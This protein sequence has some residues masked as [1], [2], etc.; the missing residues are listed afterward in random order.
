MRSDSKRQDY[1]R[2]SQASEGGKMEEERERIKKLL[3]LALI[4]ESKLS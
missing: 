1:F 3:C 2:Y 4:R